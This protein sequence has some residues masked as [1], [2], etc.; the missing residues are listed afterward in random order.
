MQGLIAGFLPLPMSLLS[1][2]VLAVPLIFVFLIVLAITA[3]AIIPNFRKQHGRRKIL[4]SIGIAAVF[5][6]LIA[7]ID[8]TV[9]RSVITYRY[10]SKNVEAYPDQVNQLH[11]SCENHGDRAA[12]FMLVLH[13]LNASFVS[14]Q[15]YCLVNSRTAKIP[16]VLAESLF[17]QNEAGKTVYFKADQNVTGFSFAI[18]LEPQ[19]FSSIVVSSGIT[20]LSFDWNATQNRYVGGMASGFDA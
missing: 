18:S 4:M 10:D 2:W 14:Q 19:L 6:V 8:L 20:S 7:G 3:V 11:F 16:F 17:A 1:P 9:R 5:L 12:S 13:S 15:D